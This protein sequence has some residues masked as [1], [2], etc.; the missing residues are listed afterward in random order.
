MTGESLFSVCVSACLYVCLVCLTVVSCQTLNCK[1]SMRRTVGVLTASCAMANNCKYCTNID[2]KLPPP[3][4]RPAFLTNIFKSMVIKK[5]KKNKTNKAKTEE[6]HLKKQT[7]KLQ[8]RRR[9]RGISNSLMVRRETSL[10]S[11][12]LLS[13]EISAAP[14]DKCMS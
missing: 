12:L 5:K 1:L 6:T 11:A 10:V 8:E 14:Y 3:E 2:D 9:V 4:E 7:N 13:Q